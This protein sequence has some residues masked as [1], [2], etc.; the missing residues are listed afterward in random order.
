VYVFAGIAKLNP[1]W[2]LDAQPLRIWLAART[3]RPI[4]GA[5]LDEPAVAHL[6][7]WAGALFDLTIVGWLL[8]KRSRPA[9]YVVVVA[10]HLATAALFQIGVFP[11]VMI[12]S[13]P[14]FFGPNWPRQVL[15]RLSKSR[16]VADRPSR[17]RPSFPVGRTTLGAIAVLALANVALPLRHYAVP[18]NVR[19]NDDGYY[20]SWRVMVSER[21]T[22]VEYHVA[23]PGTG[24]VTLVRADDLLEPWQVTQA[25]TRPDLVLATAHLIAGRDERLHGRRPIVTVDAWLSSNGQPRRRWIDPTL[26]LASVPRSAGTHSYVLDD[27]DLSG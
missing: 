12:L 3:D 19:I 6:F 10:F 14:I 7:S 26:D 27:E 22:F 2:L 1:D 8:W 18:G 25:T 13:T 4:V 17:P 24:E 16:A 9:A 15:A 21:A 5:W 20:L 23:D 11:W